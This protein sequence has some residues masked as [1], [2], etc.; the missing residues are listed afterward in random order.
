LKSQAAI[1]QV[2]SIAPKEKQAFT[3]TVSGTGGKPA[4]IFKGS[5]VRWAKPEIRKSIPNLALRDPQMPGNTP[6]TAVT[7][8]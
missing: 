5:A 8:G 2:P 7:F 3:L 1:W 6:Q 4:D